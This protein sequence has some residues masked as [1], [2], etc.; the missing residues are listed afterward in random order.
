AVPWPA[1][2]AV[3][4]AMIAALTVLTGWQHRTAR[5]QGGRE[6]AEVTQARR[7]PRRTVAEATVLVLAAG[8]LATLRLTASQGQPDAYTTVSPVLTAIAASLL[9]ARL[10]PIPVRG[11][12]PAAATRRGAVG[13]LGLAQA[14]RTQ[15]S[16]VLPVL[17]LVLTLTMA[18]F[19]AM[20]SGS[21]AA[22]QE[23]TS[24]QQVGADATIQ[25][26][27]DVISSVITGRAQRAIAA[28]PGVTSATAV[29]TAT[30]SGPLGAQLRGPSGKNRLAGLAVVD[31]APYAALAAHTPW[32]GFPAQLLVRG[33]SDSGT[34]GS[35]GGADGGAGRRPVPVLASSA[36]ALALGARPGQTVTMNLGGI[37][38]DVSIRG[39]IGRTPAMP[40]GGS[41]LVFPRWAAAGLSSIPG[42]DLLL[43]TGPGT[44]SRQFART[45][46]TSE[47]GGILTLRSQ[48]LTQLRTAPAQAAADQVDTLGLWAAA[49]LTVIA[50]LVGL[51]ASAGSR[52]LLTRR[53]TALGMAARQ[54]R[55]L[56]LAQTLPLLATGILGMLA[57]AIGL[58]LL[59][60]PA[61][62]LAVFVAGGTGAAPSFVPVQ[63]RPAALL[64]PAAGAVVVALA[65]VG[66]Q[67]VLAQ[68]RESAASAG[69]EE[70]G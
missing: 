17:A 18:A 6:R 1:A 58:A 36:L 68:R 14:A 63:P 37:V 5:Q 53:M 31:P 50:L 57:T 28:T 26:P 60:G 64:L 35:T 13:F 43:V 52:S 47:Q 66:A 65:I 39:I 51:A 62:N 33:R 67:N 59:V 45:M 24:W 41:F 42:P 54:T 46:A 49:A 11:L 48:V 55:T 34:G 69:Q 27:P 22:S 30:A 70:A 38:L 21:V 3:A 19:A 25:A 16:A 40:A 2:L 23:L 20:V 8:G 61:L 7:S 12:L 44:N 15:V 56:A 29:W 10:Y 32:G 4:A 9:A